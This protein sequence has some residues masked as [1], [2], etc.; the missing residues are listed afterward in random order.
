M[1][2]A[3]DAPWGASVPLAYPKSAGGVRPSERRFVA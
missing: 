2:A 3:T 1:S